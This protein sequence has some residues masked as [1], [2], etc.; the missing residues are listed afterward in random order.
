MIFKGFAVTISL[1]LLL[2]VLLGETTYLGFAPSKSG[3]YGPSKHI[4][5]L[6]SPYENV[7]STTKCVTTVTNDL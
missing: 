5:N 3:Q 4:G 2:G 1:R 6:K 7:S